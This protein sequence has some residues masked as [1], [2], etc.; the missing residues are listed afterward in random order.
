MARV[1]TWVERGVEISPFYDPMLAKII[2]HAADRDQA[3]AR[4]LAALNATECMASKP[5]QTISSRFWTVRYFAAA[6]TRPAS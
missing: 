2:V 3:I 5:F 6:A 1:E 4:L